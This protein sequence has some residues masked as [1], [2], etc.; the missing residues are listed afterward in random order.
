MKTRVIFLVLLIGCFS[1]GTNNKT[2]SDAQKEKIKAEVKEVVNTIFKGAEEAN[3]DMIIG[4]Y[5]NSPDFIATYDGNSFDY[6]QLTELTTSAFGTLKNQK[7]TVTDEKYTVLDH[8]TVMVT[9]NNK[10]LINYKDGHSVLQDP[11]I[12]QF[13][14]KKTDN[15]WKVIS[16]AES[17][18]EKN[19]PNKS[20]KDLNQIE[21][22]KQF[23][24][25]WQ[26]EVSKDTIEIQDIRP[27]GNAIEDDF[28]IITK[29][30]IIDSGKVLWGYDR[31][32][33]KY[34]NAEVLKSSQ[35]IRMF[36][37]WFT[38]ANTCFAVPMAYISNPDN[39]EF[40]MKA[41]FKSPD[42]FIKTI[43]RNNNVVA[44]Q[45]FNRKKN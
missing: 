11:W 29:G 17:G 12:S 31:K 7:I 35:D 8:S 23:I 42:V 16:G 27:F 3:P 22:I 14:F 26:G 44:K 5:L 37:I 21:L 19:I 18:V 20:P 39:A 30:K 40:K 15:K 45:T 9:V 28:K 34:I 41:E 38:A 6:K 32:N 10:C 43:I 36:S 4:S 33:D 13:V 1:C 2:V 25:T 24:G